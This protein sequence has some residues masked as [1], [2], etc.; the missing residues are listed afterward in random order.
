[1]PAKSRGGSKPGRGRKSASGRIVGDRRRANP[2]FLPLVCGSNEALDGGA[3]GDGEADD[4]ECEQVAGQ[5]NVLNDLAKGCER[6]GDPINA[7]RF[8]LQA[9]AMKDDAMDRGCFFIDEPID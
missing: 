1:M 9:I 4:A 3:T 8:R 6:Y 7:T 5:L 2:E